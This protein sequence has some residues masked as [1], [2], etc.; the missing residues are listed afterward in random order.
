MNPAKMTVF[1]SDLGWMA[2]VWTGRRVRE[3]TFGHRSPR[4]AASSVAT[5]GLD[6]TEPDELVQALIP[7]LQ[8]FAEG[9]T[10][11][12]FLN[13]SLEVSDMTDFQRAVIQHCRR[14]KAGETKSYGELA[15][16]AGHPN[17]ARAVGHVMA[18]N[19]FP[20]IVPCHRVVAA[21]RRLGGFSAPDGVDMKRRLLAAEGVAVK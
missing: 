8:A 13:V 10:R 5:D 2:L 11:D 6:L 19:R 3:L 18:T 21:N 20:L 4:D 14:I 15:Q 7:R 17:A 12:R 16:L 1:E 9:R